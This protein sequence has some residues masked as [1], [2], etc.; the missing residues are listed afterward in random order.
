MTHSTFL[1]I[2]LA[3]LC[4]LAVHQEPDLAAQLAAR[5]DRATEACVGLE[6]QLA[7]GADTLFH[8]ASGQGVAGDTR[9]EGEVLRAPQLL[10]AL[11][12]LAVLRMVGTEFGSPEAGSGKRLELDQAIGVYL[13]AAKFDGA[14]VTVRHLLAG[15]SGVTA[16][17]AEL[18]HEQRASATVTALLDVIVA[19]GLV[20]TP[21]H[22][23]DPNES[24]VLLLGALV[25]AATGEPL[26]ATFGA[27]FTAIGLEDTGFL[28]EADA[29]PRVVADATLELDFE[30]LAASSLAPFG[31]DRLCTTVPD[32]VRLVQAFAGR[33]L[34]DEARLAEFLAPQ[35][36]EP[37]RGAASSTGFGLG[38]DLV[39][40]GAFGG[41]SVGGGGVGGA[42]HV[43]RYPEADLTL[44]LAATA[45]D[46]PL[47]DLGRD[48][49]RM[50]LG[51]P[52]PGVQDLE[53]PAADARR[54]VG[55]YLIGCNRLDVTRRDDGHLVMT[56]I[57]RPN[58]VLLFQGGVRFVAADSGE[59]AYEFL[60]RDGTERSSGIVMQEHGQRAEAVRID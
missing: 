13:P 16:Y 39:R 26:E 10:R 7:V 18:T 21:G 4:A 58:R 40:L 17:G 14:P 30:R 1:P 52:P 41:V 55:G 48:L 5:A 36:V 46:A 19:S 45:P 27:L 35:R 24:E 38:V 9:K 15:T 49:A 51:I 22:C 47:A 42:L 34:L 57:D 25:V 20:A 37:A 31:E 11:T 59:C 3:P 8:R 50:V 54:L 44:V 23:F 53:L 32:L 12:S 60:F 28:A 29:P 33:E 56:F 2:L 43:V 6:V